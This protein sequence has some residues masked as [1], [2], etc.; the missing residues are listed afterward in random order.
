MRGVCVQSMH[1]RWSLK[2]NANPRMAMAVDASLV[3][4]GQ[5]KPTLQVK[6]ILDLFKHVI[7]DEEAGEEAE[8]HRGH[9]LANRIVG[10][11]KL[12]DQFLE[13]LLAIRAIFGSRFE[14]RGH[15]RDHLDVFSDRLLLLLDLVQ[16]GRDAFGPNG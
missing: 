11:L 5:A 12:V 2:N 4:L 16:T 15:L 14:S 13:L 10:P 8:H 6:I 3:A 1:Q 9:V 7:A